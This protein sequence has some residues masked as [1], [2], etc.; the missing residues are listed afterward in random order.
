MRAAVPHMTAL[1]GGAIV[2][3][4]AIDAQTGAWLHSDYNMN[5]G[6]ILGLTR[7][8]AVEW[9]RF[10]IRTNSIAPTGLGSV[11]AQLLNDVH[12]FLEMPTASN[13]L[14]LATAP[15]TAI[16]PLV[17]FLASDHLDVRRHGSA[18]L[19]TGIYRDSS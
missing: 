11:F 17:V 14:Q 6:P 7:S 18:C 1:G 4:Y 16:A 10:N 15:D 8:A 3:F 13:P 5:T 9:G 12:G 19:S 2:N